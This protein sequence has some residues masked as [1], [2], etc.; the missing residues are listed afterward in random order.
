MISMSLI[1]V[2]LEGSAS[3]RRQPSRASRNQITAGIV[4]AAARLHMRRKIHYRTVTVLLLITHSAQLP[5]IAYLQATVA[6]LSMFCFGKNFI[7]KIIPHEIL[8]RL[9]SSTQ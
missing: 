8:Y 6:Q 2:F 9:Q 7:H 1:D 5:S 3:E 4:R